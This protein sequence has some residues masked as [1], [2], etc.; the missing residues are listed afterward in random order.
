MLLPGI[1]Q[2]GAT[3][4]AESIRQSIAA[5]TTCYQGHEIRVT[6]SAGISSFP[7]HAD[8]T[9]ELIAAADAGLYQAKATGRDR[10]CCGCEC[11]V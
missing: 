6:L 8:S 11:L 1:G 7:A 5:A 9:E 4:I 2:A 10:V 3:R